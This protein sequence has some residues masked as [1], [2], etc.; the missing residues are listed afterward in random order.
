VG[1][2][3]L[4]CSTQESVE[5]RV[6]RALALIDELA[7][8]HDLLVLPELWNTGAFDLDACRE[9]AQD[10]DGPLPSALSAKAREHGIWLHGGSLCEKTSNGALHNTSVLFDPQG[11][12]A[13]YYRKIHVFT[14][15]GEHQTMTPGSSLV[16]VETPLGL[17]G[18]ATC[19]DLRFPEQFRAMTEA[20]AESFLVASG[21]PNVRIAHWD[22]LITA[23]AIENQAWIVACNEV[24]TQHG[25]KL[26]G[27]STIVDPL[28]VV[29]ARGGD[30][31]ECVSHVCD[32]ESGHQWRADFPAL[33][34]IVDFH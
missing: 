30:S 31:Q 12:L 11:E 16:M 21:W 25:L 33:A 13:A 4:D 3:Q 14:Y 8:T 34:D 26:G 5:N 24:G 17:T 29:H 10:L 19:Y 1:A 18:L 20:G 2:L 28:G 9:Y 22:A 6:A 27:H 15:G 23:R 32:P 7:P